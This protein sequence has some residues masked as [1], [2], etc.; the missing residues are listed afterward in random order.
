MMIGPSAPNGP[1]VP[2]E[3]AADTGLSTAT[4]GAIR[5]P[6]VRIASM[7]SSMP[8][9]RIFSLPYRAISPISRSRQY[10]ATALAAPTGSAI[11]V[12]SSARPQREVAKPRRVPRA[13]CRAG[14]AGPD[15]SPGGHSGSGP[16][17]LSAVASPASADK[18]RA[19]RAA[20][21]RS[22][23]SIRSSTAASST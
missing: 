18:R 23:G 20:A 10:A 22:P 7:A 13:L 12:I 5:L 4:R 15:G 6:P 17:A 2:I 21:S 1:P 3:I 9:P 16:V 14:R 8:W 19:R 11:A